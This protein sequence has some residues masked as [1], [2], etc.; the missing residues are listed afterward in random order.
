MLDTFF[1][2]R[3]CYLLALPWKSWKLYKLGYI[4]DK[5]NLIS[6]PDKKDFD[7]FTEIV[8]RIKKMIMIVLRSNTILA[9]IVWNYLLPSIEK[10]ELEKRKS[11]PSSLK[12][13]F[14]FLSN[15][16]SDK[17]KKEKLDGLPIDYNSPDVSR[18][19]VD[20][21]TETFGM[22]ENDE[23]IENLKKTRDFSNHSAVNIEF[24]KKGSKI[25]VE[26]NNQIMGLADFLRR[27]DTKL[28]IELMY[29]KIV[30][31]YPYER[32]GKNKYEV[33]G[34]FIKKHF[35]LNDG[36]YDVRILSGTSGNYRTIYFNL[37]E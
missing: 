12:E 13:D 22:D 17:K 3:L 25:R 15:P 35:L 7:E 21:G 24:F 20:T 31:D 30:I 28:I 29:N 8:R 10:I 5:G 36:I 34:N 2:Y 4:D 6:K 19:S 33:V 27:N 37:E 14:Q 1:R 18:G 11:L 23:T 32:S 26:M 9:I 16:I